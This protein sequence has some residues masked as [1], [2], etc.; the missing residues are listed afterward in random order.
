MLK[1]RFLSIFLPALEVGPQGAI[2]FSR[3]ALVDHPSGRVIAR[4]AD[5]LWVAGGIGFVR[6]EFEGLV[7]LALRLFSS[8]QSSS[9]AIAPVQ[10]GHVAESGIYVNARMVARYNDAFRIWRSNA[11]GSTEWH[12]ILAEPLA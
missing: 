12:T 8:N 1:L 2:S 4:Y 3:G 10:A 9:R 6:I 7:P 11:D 5:N